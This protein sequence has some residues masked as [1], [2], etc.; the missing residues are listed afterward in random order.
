MTTTEITTYELMSKAEAECAI[1]RADYTQNNDSIF[2]SVKA[3][4]TARREGFYWVKITCKMEIFG[5][6]MKAVGADAM[7]NEIENA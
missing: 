6:F 7:E 5:A 1:E 4:I 3:D 2:E